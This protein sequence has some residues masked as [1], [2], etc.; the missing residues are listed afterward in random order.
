M[1]VDQT[2]KAQVRAELFKCAIAGRFLTY[3]E[4]FDCIRP[5][6]KMGQFPYRE[7]FDQIA[8]EERNNGYPDITFLVHR[9][10]ER[11]RYPSQIDFRP[12]DPPDEQQLDS[13][14]KGTDNL[15]SLYCPQ[16]RNPYR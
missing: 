1:P 7:H 4:F 15:I 14:L 16:T 13:L 11:P 6:G 12:A 2:L 8:R 5:G 3:A 9:G 10:G